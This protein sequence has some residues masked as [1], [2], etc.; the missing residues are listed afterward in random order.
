MYVHKLNLMFSYRNKPLLYS[1]DGDVIVRFDFWCFG[2][3]IWFDDIY[4]LRAN[5]GSQSTATCSHATS[6][7][8]AAAKRNSPSTPHGHGIV[9][10]RYDGRLDQRR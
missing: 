5:R 4:F 1:A 9:R 10:R 3:S 6:Q 2:P 7:K 8:Q